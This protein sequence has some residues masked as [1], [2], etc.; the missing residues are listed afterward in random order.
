M[1]KKLCLAALSI[2]CVSCYQEEKN[3][4]DFKTGTFKFEQEINGEIHQSTFVRNDSIEIETYMGKT[5]TA[6]I[7]WINDCEY[8]L[9][10]INPKNMAEQ[11]GIHMKILSTSKNE[12]TF[13]YGLVGEV[14][15]QRG[16]IKKISE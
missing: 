15:K 1:K 10:K 11:K 4:A 2:L 7:R 13:E 12:Y 16:I 8:I 14:E 9:Q 3:C 5:D 6:S